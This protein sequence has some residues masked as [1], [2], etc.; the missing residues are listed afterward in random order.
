[1]AVINTGAAGVQQ[2]PEQPRTTLFALYE[3]SHGEKCLLSRV[4][5]SYFVIKATGMTLCEM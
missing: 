2:H 3:R 1:M 4:G 5:G